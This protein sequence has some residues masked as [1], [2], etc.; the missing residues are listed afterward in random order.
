MGRGGSEVARR[1]ETARLF[2]GALTAF[3]W[4]AGSAASSFV[5]R[6]LAGI[7][8]S[9]RPAFSDSRS[10]GT[11]RIDSLPLDGPP[12]SLAVSAVARPA[13][14]LQRWA[15][16]GALGRGLSGLAAAASA[17]SFVA[18]DWLRV[19][20]AAAAGLGCGLVSTRPPAAA[21]LVVVGLLLAAA[22]PRVVAVVRTSGVA[23]LFG[24][25]GAVAPAQTGRFVG[26]F[27]R[28][29]GAAW[30]AMLLAAVA[31]ALTGAGSGTK[32]V[33]ALA[34]VIAAAAA[35]LWRPQL[36]LL[37][38]AAFPWVDW[39]ARHTLGGFGPL[40]DDALLVLSAALVL[41][42]VLALGRDT[43]RSLPISLPVLLMLVACA[44]SV[45]VNRVPSNVGFYALR[46]LFEP[47]LFY[48]VGFL[49][50]KDRRWVRWTMGVFILTSTL[51]AL[52]GLYQYV[53]HAPMPGN[54]VDVTE[55]GIGTR[56]FS[57]VQ[58]PNVLGGI[59][60]MGALISGSLALSRAFSGSRRV[61]VLAAC[62]VQLGG[63]AA[64]FSRGAWIGFAVGVL[65][66]IILA[67]RR[68]IVGMVAVGVVAW[69]VAP[70][71]FIQRILFSFSSAYAAKS[72]TGLGRLF[73]W[74]SA[75]SH[76]ADKPLLGVGLGTFGG[77]A[78][79]MFGYWAL[80]V[81]NFYLQMAAEGGL[82][83]LVFFLWLLLRSA[84]GLIRGYRVAS[85]PY[86][87]ALAAGML[88]AFV[89]VVV[90]D[91]FE[92][93]WETLSV[94][95]EFWFLAGLVTSALLVKVK[96]VARP[97]ENGAPAPG[98]LAAADPTPAAKAGKSG[99]APSGDEAAR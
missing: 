94:G 20:G 82:L 83:L 40:W 90:A 45:V 55:T 28:I 2:D 22:G 42:A 70:Q 78:A 47:I 76:I 71:V 98:Q 99:A 67:Y 36:V 13:V 81:D 77:T 60:A 51:L 14:G 43:P 64:T 12:D 5:G 66:M 30:V 15:A 69:F 95:A 11:S 26:G 25:G 80:W 38:A 73:R 63:L 48:F 6:A 58:N 86:L 39:L 87:K 92:A 88:G 91:F 16:G 62:I 3:R 9:A 19:A 23:G 29:R 79:Y 1:A 44:G 52:H 50:P 4:A 17:S 54:W 34:F 61:A 93:D 27:T 24:A 56:A 84:K 8:R 37:V 59:L 46:V 68:Y 85:D 7:A 21:V 74:E 97:G 10:L 18:G 33:L 75:L 31:G 32:M 35:V 72:N 65:I 96:P 49:L 53:T 41:W 57:V 89:A